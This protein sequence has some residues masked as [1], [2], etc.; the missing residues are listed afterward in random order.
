MFSRESDPYRFVD[1]N[2]VD[3]SSEDT[4]GLIHDVVRTHI[5]CIPRY[6]KGIEYNIVVYE[7]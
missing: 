2:H 7:V 3:A 5:E 6:N 4:V 1:Q